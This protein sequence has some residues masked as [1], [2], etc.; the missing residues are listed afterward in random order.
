MLSI[1][2]LITLLPVLALVN[3]FPFDPSQPRLVSRQSTGNGTTSA[4]VGGGAAPL[5]FQSVGDAGISAQM[6][7]SS[8][9]LTCYD[10]LTNRCGLETRTKSTSSTRPRTIPSLSMVNS[11]HIPLGPS[12]TTSSPIPVSRVLLCDGDRA[13]D[14]SSNGCAFQ[15]FLC[16]WCSAR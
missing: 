4:D 5:S 12:S 2:S 7:R 16:L 13:D 3:A 9:A 14:R 10:E 8:H 6:V 15:H 1:T 11:V